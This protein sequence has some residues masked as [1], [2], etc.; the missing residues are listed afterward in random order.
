M[1]ASE[2]RRREG[3]WGQPHHNRADSIVVDNRVSKVGII[4]FGN[5]GTRMRADL[6]GLD[7]AKDNLLIIKN[8][9]M[10]S[11]L[12]LYSRSIN[13]GDQTKRIA[14]EIDGKLFKATWVY[15]VHKLWDGYSKWDYLWPTSEPWVPA[16]EPSTY[17]AVLGALGLGVVLW[18]RKRPLERSL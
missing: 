3:V 15:K 6:V 8:W 18:R 17:G 9:N 13:L 16:P 11:T 10:Y 7:I 2:I 1:H 4:D 12:Y 5:L 14:F